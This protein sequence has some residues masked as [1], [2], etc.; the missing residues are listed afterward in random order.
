MT[1][2]LNEEERYQ[3]VLRSAIYE[4][5]KIYENSP[6]KFKLILHSD[7][8]NPIGRSLGLTNSDSN[9][10]WADITSGSLEARLGVYYTYLTEGEKKKIKEMGILLKTMPQGTPIPGCYI[11]ELILQESKPTE[12]VAKSSKRIED[13]VA[14]AQRF[15]QAAVTNHARVVARAKKTNGT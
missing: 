14:S 9:K 13:M 1:Y 3:F 8:R 7:P 15:A 4:G 5:S 11:S 2:T 6:D 12:H 10:I